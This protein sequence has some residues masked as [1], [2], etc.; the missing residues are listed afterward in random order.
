MN[1]VKSRLMNI[2]GMTC[3]LNSI[4]HILYN[5]DKLYHIIMSNRSL[6][7]DTLISGL[8]ELFNAMSNN[9]G[10]VIRPMLFLMQFKTAFNYWEVNK[11]QDSDEF[12]A[13][14]LFKMNED[15][16]DKKKYFICNVSSNENIKHKNIYYIYFSSLFEKNYI[17]EYS[18]ISNLTKNFIKWITKCNYCNVK[19]NGLDSN[20]T[21]RLPLKETNTPIDIY[22]CLDEFI[23][24]KKSERKC[25]FCNIS[26]VCI[27][28]ELFW[29]LP[30]ILIISFNRFN[31]VLQKINTPIKLNNVIDLY[32][33]FDKNSPYRNKTK[34]ELIAA[35]VHEG[36]SIESG[37]YI[38]Y[39][40]LDD[41]RW[42]VYNDHFVR[43]EDIINCN[44]PYILF[45]QLIQ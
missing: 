39:I 1:I 25:E 19:I 7:Q 18:P 27:M 45:Y 8:Y 9:T 37:H 44:K 15:L 11:Q 20:F 34:Y 31:N 42:L 41:T 6:P 12:L 14:L 26:S 5:T 29:K 32:D 43:L 3:Y 28:R 21:L 40:K 13:L 16:E 36:F 24:C 30:D 4:L 22:E 35:N 17:T 33:Y 10:K 23:E 2:N 38:S